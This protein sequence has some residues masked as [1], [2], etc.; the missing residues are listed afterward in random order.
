MLGAIAGDIIGSAHEFRPPVAGDFVL[1]SDSSRFTDDSVL[2]I[3]V[4][5]CILHGL[6]YGATI[7][8]YGLRYPA[9]GYGAAFKK[10]L[11]AAAAGPYN[12]YGNG[13]A[14]RVSPVGFAFDSLERVE[15][16][17]RSSA[18]VTHNHPEGIKGAQAVAAAVFLARQGT[19]KDD[20]LNFICQR[21]HYDSGLYRFHLGR[22][23]ADIRRQWGTF[24]SCQDTVPP[25]LVIFRESESYED[26][27]R[28]AVSLG[29]DTD[30]LACI[31]GA[32]AQ[33]FYR[34]IPP[35]IV[36]GVRQRLDAP[37]LR[38]VEEF[39]QYYML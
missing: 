22:S 21:Y 18:E 26:C 27:V 38:V 31:C 15:F 6:P 3:A 8:E 37:L 13:S 34:V 24:I 12:S 11:H 9:A 10:W 1:F 32:I 29:G 7:R 23:L 36:A 20:I 16:E 14:M 30:T 5:D 19:S 28:K 39:N 33:A 17:A 35:H 25:A 4:A 2:T